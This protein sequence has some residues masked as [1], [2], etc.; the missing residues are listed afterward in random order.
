MPRAYHSYGAPDTDA[1][2]TVAN[3]RLRVVPLLLSLC[4]TRRVCRRALQASSM[5]T[6]TS[7][8]CACVRCALCTQCTLT[9]CGWSVQ[10]RSKD[11]GAQVKEMIDYLS[12]AGV[13]KDY[14]MVWLDI[15]AWL[16]LRPKPRPPPP[17]PPP[18]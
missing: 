11:P 3:V 1:P 2:H 6:S 15:G 12:S 5:S 7:S 10:C 9:R 17:P 4:V 8:R 18:R 16:L 14:S 13:A